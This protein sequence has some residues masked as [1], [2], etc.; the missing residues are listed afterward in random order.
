MAGLA[1][2]RAAVKTTLEAAISGLKV[3]P[4]IEA[5]ST[6]PAVVVIPIETDFVVAM[7]RGTDTYAFELL[8]LVPSGDLVVAQSKLDPFITG[9]GSSSIRQA[10]FSA[11]TLGLTNTN[12]HVTAMTGYGSQY[13]SAGLAHVGATLHLT[14]HTP[15]TA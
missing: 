7:G 3:Y 2:I 5:V 15:G 6:T 13:E 12:A 8:V 9:A 10:V 11:P 4:A 1:E 14:V